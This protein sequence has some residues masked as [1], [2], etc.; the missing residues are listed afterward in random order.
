[1]LREA[2]GWGPRRPVHQM[3]QG[4]L[5]TLGGRQVIAFGFAMIGLSVFLFGAYW[6]MNMERKRWNEHMRRLE[7]KYR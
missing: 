1:M 5:S 6:G 2:R 7:R 4:S 3:S